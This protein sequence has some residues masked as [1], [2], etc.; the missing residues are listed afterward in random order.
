MH[1]YTSAD[2]SHWTSPFA[3]LP[4]QKCLDK[5]KCTSERG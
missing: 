4:G 1:L 3:F 5:Y 2:H